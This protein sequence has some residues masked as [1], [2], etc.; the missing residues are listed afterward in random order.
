MDKI[1]CINC[2]R[3]IKAKEE[4]TSNLKLSILTAICKCGQVNMEYKDKFYF[5]PS[6]SGIL[7]F[8]NT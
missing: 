1:K 7:H 2:S 8:E 4:I 6:N 3:M 5:I